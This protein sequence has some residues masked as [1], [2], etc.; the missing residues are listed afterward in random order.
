MVLSLAYFPPLSWFAVAARDFTL[1]ADRVIPSVVTIEACENYQKQSYRNRCLIST[2]NGVEALSVP[3]VHEGGTFKLPIR[4]IRVDYSVP[5]VQR[6]QRAISSAYDSSAFFEY[7]RDELFAILDSRPETLWEL[8]M[9]IIDFFVRK[10]GIAVQLRPSEV[11]ERHPE[12]DL[13][14]VIHPK[15]PNGILAQLGLEKPYFQVFS[16]KY[17]FRSDLSVMD[18]LF[19]AGPDSIMYLKS[20]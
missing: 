18:L 11:Y 14:D 2:A 3:V 15:R 10:T 7:Y 8:D 17:G 6:S 13:R 5:W 9:A 12:E 20:F 16:G 1:S 4:S 19:N